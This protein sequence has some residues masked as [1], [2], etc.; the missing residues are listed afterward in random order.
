MLRHL[1]FDV[2]ETLLDV[3]ALDPLFVRLFGDASARVEWFLTLEEGWMTATI[4]E[5]FQPFA[6]LAQAALVM[7]GQRREIE[8][9]E[10]QCEE[11]VEG[12]KRLPA[13]PEVRPAL[14]QLRGAGFHLAA[15]SNGSLQALRQQLESAGL[16]D[17]FD[18]ILSVEETQRYKP[19]PEPYR[20]AA[21]CI[22]IEQEQ[23]MMVAAHAWDITGAAAVGCRTAFIARPG[24]VLNPAGSQPDIQ[25]NDL[26]DFARQLLAWRER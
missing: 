17:S 9:S 6:K 10:A 22:G 11:L 23:M 21:K 13:H 3:A 12:M 20:M 1:V 25:G 8:V 5:R 15:L 2:N 7:V 4:V 26:Q 24:K 14:E 18:A 19:A 16:G